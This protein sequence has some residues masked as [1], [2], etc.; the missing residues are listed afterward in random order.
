VHSGEIGAGLDIQSA[1]DLDELSE[2]YIREIVARQESIGLDVVSDG[3]FGRILFTDS[4]YGAVK[5]F[6]LTED[7]GVF[8]DKTGAEVTVPFVPTPAQRLEVTGNPLADEAKL[9]RSLTQRAFK[10]TLPAA[11]LVCTPLAY[12]ADVFRDA[13]ATSDDAADHIVAIQREIIEGAIAEGARYIQ[14]DFAMYPYW[15]DEHQ[16]AQLQARG[17][18]LDELLERF[19][20]VDRAV[21]EG[22][23]SEVATAVHLCRGN[24][25]SKWM[26]EGSIEPVAERVFHELPYKR[27][28]LEMD[29]VDRED[30][31]TVLRHAPQGEDGPV[32]VLGLISSKNPKLEDEDEVMRAIDEASRYLPIDQLALSPQ[33]GF[34]SNVQG[35]EVTEDDQWRK[36][37]LIARVADRVW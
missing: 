22:L 10:L 27:F 23:P 4:F 8:H 16:R 14:L 7:K 28:L 9:L 25:K 11:S 18:D 19:L 2:R 12:R 17:V 6:V 30:D 24:L 35:N 32:V 33:C 21:I 20:R 5:G 29:D 37:E 3:E 15:V 1:E 31:F 34:A 36:L 13:Y 26:Y